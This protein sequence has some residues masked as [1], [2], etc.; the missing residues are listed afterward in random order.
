VPFGP[1]DPTIPTPSW[2]AYR[3]FA[4][5]ACSTLH[6]YLDSPDG[7]SVGEFGRAMAAVCDA[8]VEG[9]QDQWAVAAEA[10]GKADPSTLADDC[11]A[12]VVKD[13]LDRALAWH[14]RHPGL[15]P[16]VRFQRL[17]GETDCG[18]KS[19]TENSEATTPDSGTSDSEPPASDDTSDTQPSDTDA[20]GGTSG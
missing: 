11:L 19:K 3:A 16:P 4:D 8:A 20:S 9:R 17:A 18:R 10:A 6:D 7:E 5:G 12:G 13:L 2:P 1:S 14:Q 15:N